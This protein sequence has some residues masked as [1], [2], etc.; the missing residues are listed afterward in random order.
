MKYFCVFP[1]CYVNANADSVL[2]INPHTKQYVYSVS[3]T[4]VESFTN[5]KNSYS[6]CILD[7]QDQFYIDALS[8]HL[9]YIIESIFPPYYPNP[10]ISFVSSM[11][12]E[13]RALGYNTGWNIPSF[14]KSVSFH[15][16]NRNL[17]L[18]QNILF[19]QLE[20]PKQDE[21]SYKT[22]KQLWN[23]IFTV[24]SN[25]PIE[26]ITLCGDI[27]EL[28][29]DTLDKIEQI[30]CNRVVIRT[31]ICEYEKAKNILC[32][33]SNL[34]IELVVNNITVL[35]KLLE[36]NN[37]PY[38]DITFTIPLL[39]LDDFKSL[40]TVNLQVTYVPLVY[41]IKLQSELIEQILL[42]LD[43]ILNSST[44]IE[45]ILI[46]G[47]I[48]S[49][50][51]GSVIIKRDGLLYVADEFI[52][53]TIHESIYSLLNK[54]L[55]KSQ[56]SGM[57]TRNK[58]SSCKKCLFVQLC[59]NISIYEKQGILKRACLESVHTNIVTLLSSNYK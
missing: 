44:S 45:G 1:H 43:D 33:Y 51:W 48:N 31:A 2:V 17:R 56:N 28:L 46:K 14:I 27:D 37:V 52:G 35:N 55:Q 4:I 49:N 59:P 26:I 3:L 40:D 41:D 47:I 30:Y 25:S 19:S 15:F 36:T 6:Y 8:K 13:K 39:S 22:N 57:M 21:I 38:N 11:G 20:Y 54:W 34:K 5:N 53:N 12:K 50:F 23:E 16:N 29:L 7:E 10:K 32:K 18:P 58:Y 9:G 42:N 24:L